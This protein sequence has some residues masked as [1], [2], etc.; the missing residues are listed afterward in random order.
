MGKWERTF[1][2]NDDIIKCAVEP[3]SGE[4][5]AV[6]DCGNMSVG[7]MG[8]SPKD[9]IGLCLSKLMDLLDRTKQSLE[10]IRLVINEEE[11]K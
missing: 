9:A 10:S 8:E 1:F 2:V 11:S 3:S 5:L 6:M 7:S 4:W